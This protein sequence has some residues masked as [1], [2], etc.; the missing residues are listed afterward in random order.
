MTLEDKSVRPDGEF[1]AKPKKSKKTR[2]YTKRVKPTRRTLIETVKVEVMSE[3]ARC[4]N[5]SDLR[6]CLNKYIGEL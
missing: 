3:I 5:F 1:K 6:D 2:K 4:Q